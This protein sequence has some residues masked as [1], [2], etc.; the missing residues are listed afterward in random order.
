MN[1]KLQKVNV[2]ISYKN[3]KE[4]IEIQRDV[5]LPV[6]SRGF[7][8]HALNK[9][10]VPLIIAEDKTLKSMDNLRS[11][12]IE[13]EPEL[14][15]GF[16]S[17]EGKSIKKLNWREIQEVAVAYELASAPSYKQ[18]ELSAARKKL[19]AVFSKKVLDV[20]VDKKKIE[21]R[22]KKGQILSS[23]EVACDFDLFAMEDYIFPISEGNSLEENKN[24][25]D[26]ETPVT[27]ENFVKKSAT[28]PKIKSKDDGLK[29][30]ANEIFE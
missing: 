13:E 17:F 18:M 25:G 11:V 1:E 4:I 24:Y 3:E 7:L 2:S 10:M 30:K 20:V 12:F 19:Y 16:P 8:Q 14:V 27:K 28:Q 22:G 9:R 5:I 21:T 29:A 15:A 23:R 26:A 6:C